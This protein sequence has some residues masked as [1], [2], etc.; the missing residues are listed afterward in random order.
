MGQRADE[1]HVEKLT[2]DSIP[3]AQSVRYEMYIIRLEAHVRNTSTTST[4]ALVYLPSSD[5]M[6]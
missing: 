1:K 2:F 6:K 5:H 4:C 3:C